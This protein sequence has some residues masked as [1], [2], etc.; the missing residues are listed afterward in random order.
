MRNFIH[1]ALALIVTGLGIFTTLTFI[2]PLFY[3]AFPSDKDRHILII[4]ALNEGL[5][6]ENLI[7]FGD[8]RTMFGV[9]TRIIKREM[10]TPFDVINLSSVG[11]DIYESSYFYGLIGENTKA[12]IQCTSPAFFSRNLGYHHISDD[13]ALSMCLSGY[14]INE[15]TKSL[16]KGY[17]EVFNRKE[18]INYFKARSIIRTYIHSNI[19]RPLLDNETFDKTARRSI[20]F[21]HTYTTKKHPDYPVYNYDCSNFKSTESPIAQL[22]FLISVRDFFRAKGMEYII[23]LM[24]VNPDECKDCYEDFRKYE[25]VIKETTTLNV[26]NISDLLLDPEYFYDATHANKEG[27][28]IISSEIAKQLKYL[29]EDSFSPIGLH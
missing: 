24:P 21:P 12:I 29:T 1:T 18:F 11:Q 22:S 7:V 14:R 6:A 5:K 15:S 23:V 26:I 20:Y 10:N 28:I 4:D 27:A 17:N 13:V 19:M 25:E 8:S 2:Q 9:D 3:R 16:I